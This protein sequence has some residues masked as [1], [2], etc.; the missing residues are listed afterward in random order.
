MSV[1]L[2]CPSCGT[3]RSTPGR[4]EACQEA[5]VRY[6]CENHTPGVWLPG[7]SCGQCGAAF[8]EPE[9]PASRVRPPAPSARRSVAPPASSMAPPSRKRA[10]AGPAEVTRSRSPEWRPAVADEDGA[11]DLPIRPWQALLGAALRRHYLARVAR[12]ERPPSRSAAGGCLR[13]LIVLI[14][15]LFIALVLAVILL[16]RQLL[17]GQYGAQLRRSDCLTSSNARASAALGA[18]SR[19]HWNA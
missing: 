13:R 11:D 8:G 18:G 10:P 5:D 12:D 3:T 1:V 4:C 15:V 16:G 7:P 19:S 9:R 17:R 6:F 2:R 14:L